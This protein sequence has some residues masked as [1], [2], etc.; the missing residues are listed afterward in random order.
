M[1][2]G[3]LVESFLTR[4]IL[5]HLRGSLRALRSGSRRSVSQALDW[6]M[7]PLR[8]FSDH[9]PSFRHVLLAILQYVTVRLHGRAEYSNKR[10]EAAVFVCALIQFRQ[11]R[12]GHG[13]I[14]CIG[15]QNLS[16][17]T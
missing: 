3:N 8:E 15:P 14:G 7:L 17:R 1:V 16:C 13:A 6:T 5:E 2:N 9:A 12:Q 10:R 4:H 11:Q